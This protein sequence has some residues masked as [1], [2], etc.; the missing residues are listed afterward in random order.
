MTTTRHAANEDV[1]VAGEGFHADTVAEDGAAGKRAAG[2]DRHD[3]DAVPALPEHFGQRGDKGALADGGRAGDTDESGIS[4][5]IELGEFGGDGCAVGLHGGQE[6][7]Q[8]AAIAPAYPINDQ[9]DAF[10][11]KSRM[12]ETILSRRAPGLKM[13]LIP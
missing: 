1:T 4:V 2:V 5:G 6:F 7:C 11:T 9:D 12:T 13:A 8:G 3:S 10:T